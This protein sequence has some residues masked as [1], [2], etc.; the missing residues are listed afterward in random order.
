M[1]T[2]EHQPDGSG[3]AQPAVAAIGGEPFVTAVRCDGGRQIIRIG[4]GMQAEDLIPD[5]HF[6]GAEPEVFEGACRIVA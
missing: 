4:Q 2:R 1:V 5:P 3:K 6:I